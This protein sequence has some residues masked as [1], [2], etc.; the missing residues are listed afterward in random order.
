MRR[1]VFPLLVELG[2]WR[3]EEEEAYGAIEVSPFD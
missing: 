1:C 2:W 3:L